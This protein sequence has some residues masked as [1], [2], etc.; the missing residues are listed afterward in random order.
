MKYQKKTESGLFEHEN[1]LES[2]LKMENLLVM[3][4]EIVDFQRFMDELEK[5]FTNNSKKNRRKATG[6][7]QRNVAGLNMFQGS[8]N[9][10]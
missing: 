3:L 10:V 4:K 2:L 7:M 1:T 8:Q 9:R 6:T 5:Q